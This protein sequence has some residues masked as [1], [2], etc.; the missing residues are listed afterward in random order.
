MW[1]DDEFPANDSAL[2]KN[3]DEKPGYD[4]KEEKVEIE[5]KRPQDIIGKDE[6][7]VMTKEGMTSGDVKM[8]NLDDCW[9]LGSFLLLGTRP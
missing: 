6:T 7:P 4:D 9:L 3:P 1:V 2:Y 8:G 5:W